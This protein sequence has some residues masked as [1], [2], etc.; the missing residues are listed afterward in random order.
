[1]QV[2]LPS[3]FGTEPDDIE[4]SLERFY[5]LLLVRATDDDDADQLGEEAA[6][7][8]KAATLEMPEGLGDFLK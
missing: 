6:A 8:P 2:V 4:R 5:L 3:F 7:T 1:M